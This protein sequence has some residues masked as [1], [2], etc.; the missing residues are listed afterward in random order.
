MS[1]YKQ[2]LIK[3]PKCSRKFLNIPGLIIHT[4]YFHKKPSP[5]E[6]SNTKTMKINDAQLHP[7]SDSMSAPCKCK[8]CEQSFRNRFNLS[9]HI[10]A[11]HDRQK[12]YICHIC[13][14]CFS[15]AGSM[16]RHIKTIHEKHTCDVCG[17]RFGNESHLKTHKNQAHALKKRN[18]LCIMSSGS[19]S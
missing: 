19:K 18:F 4:K 6:T 12:S 13:N 5:V 7:N 15:Q 9:C 3:C 10:E 2:K 17:G 16:R 14:S 11:V 1:L 8:L